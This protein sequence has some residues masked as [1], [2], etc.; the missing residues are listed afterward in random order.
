MTN[1]S[2]FLEKGLDAASGFSFWV[3]SAESR[4]KRMSDSGF[5][6]PSV[7]MQS[8]ASV[9]PRRIASTPSWIAVLLGQGVIPEE[10]D[11]LVDGM[12][13]A[14]VQR[15]MAELRTGYQRTAM[16]LPL[17]S[18]F[19]SRKVA[20]AEQHLPGYERRI[21]EAFGLQEEL[22]AKRAEL[23]ALEADLAANEC[24]TNDDATAEVAAA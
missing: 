23:H 19:I 2:R 7:P 1:P 8:A 22:D 17:A 14:Q 3:E 15:A 9:S 11:P 20:E 16:K 6:E 12:P 21:G 10:Y 4:E 5:T 18:D 13:D 24:A